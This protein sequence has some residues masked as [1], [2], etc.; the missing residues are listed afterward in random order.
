MVFSLCFCS[1]GVP[2]RCLWGALGNSNERRWLAQQVELRDTHRC[3]SSTSCS[4]KLGS[5][6]CFIETEVAR[7]EQWLKAQTM[8]SL[9]MACLDFPSWVGRGVRVEPACLSTLGENRE[10]LLSTLANLLS[11]SGLHGGAQVAAGLR[12]W[13]FL[14]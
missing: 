3:L 13:L 4:Y 12:V 9:L 14:E 2:E 5:S 7:S 1:S 10:N 6:Y 11:P 8:W